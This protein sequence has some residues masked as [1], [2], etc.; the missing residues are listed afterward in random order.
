MLSLNFTNAL[1]EFMQQADVV[2]PRIACQA[3]GIV[4]WHFVQCLAASTICFMQYAP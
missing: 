2:M 3:Y 4:Q 1:V